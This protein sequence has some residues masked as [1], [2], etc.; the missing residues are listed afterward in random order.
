MGLRSPPHL[1][2][3]SKLV[4]TSLYL[5]GKNKDKFQGLCSLVL[6]GK[7]R[8]RN[9]GGSSLPNKTQEPSEGTE[10]VHL[11]KKRSWLPTICR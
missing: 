4:N 5:L 10:K 6:M 3:V 7:L 8:L 9:K 11:K 1:H 2:L